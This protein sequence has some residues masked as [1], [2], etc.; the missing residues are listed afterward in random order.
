VFRNRNVS[1][2]LLETSVTVTHMTCQIVNYE[3]TSVSFI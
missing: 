2:D 1:L 3:S